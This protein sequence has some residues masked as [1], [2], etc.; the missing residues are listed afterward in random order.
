MNLGVDDRSIETVPAA[1][2]T[3][4]VGFSPSN[5]QGKSIQTASTTS[6]YAWYPAQFKGSDIFNGCLAA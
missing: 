3:E 5:S 1:V 2:K 4:R 6:I